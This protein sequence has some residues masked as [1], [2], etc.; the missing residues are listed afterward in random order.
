MSQLQAYSDSGYGDILIDSDHVYD[1][2]DEASEVTVPALP[3]D[4]QESDN[5]DETIGSFEELVIAF[6]E[7]RTIVAAWLIEVQELQ[8]VQGGK[9]KELLGPVVTSVGKFIFSSTQAFSVVEAYQR[10]HEAELN[11]TGSTFIRLRT[12]VSISAFAS[13]RT[14]SSATIR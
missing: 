5:E 12:S 8:E 6:G 2:A 9:H 4:V 13:T 11:R 10:A 14:L 1:S 7:V 3:P